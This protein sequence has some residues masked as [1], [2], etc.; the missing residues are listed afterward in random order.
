MGVRAHFPH[1]H[2]GR[3]RKQMASASA[4]ETQWLLEARQLFQAHH[5]PWPCPSPTP[6]ALYAAT[7][8]LTSVTQQGFGRATTRQRLTL[9]LWVN[10]HTEDWLVVLEPLARAFA[11]PVAHYVVCVP[12]DR[13]S[14]VSGAGPER[15]PTGVLDRLAYWYWA[16]P[17]SRPDA[18]LRDAWCFGVYDT[19]YDPK[20]PDW[21][22]RH[23]LAL[24]SRP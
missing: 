3:Q 7:R 9:V 14:W 12:D 18:S 17:A 8:I 5:V 11:L 16:R 10:P 21:E 20:E 1:P 6:W 4:V 15:W 13:V 2:S 23:V 19:V 24:C 22:F